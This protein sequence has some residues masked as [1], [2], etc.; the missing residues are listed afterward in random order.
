MCSTRL[1]T[2]CALCLIGT[3]Q[4]NR[5]CRDATANCINT[6]DW[7][8]SAK[9]QTKTPYRERS[10]ECAFEVHQFSNYFVFVLHRSWTMKNAVK[11]DRECTRPAYEIRAI[12]FV[13][14]M[15]QCVQ[16]AR[17]LPCD[18][19]AGEWRII[20]V[21]RTGMRS[22]IIFSLS[23][24]RWW[25]QS[26][27]KRVIFYH[28][29]TIRYLLR[30]QFILRE[31]AILTHYR[32]PWRNKLEDV[33]R[34]ITLRMPEDKID[35]AESNRKRRRICRMAIFC[36]P[37]GKNQNVEMFMQCK[38]IDTMSLHN[39]RFWKWQTN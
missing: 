33:F 9:T 21:Q 7:L 24:S 30:F 12:F 27:G 17:C 35:V 22:I 32:V 26:N 23:S 5:L 13:V 25:N 31:Q 39:G 11:R 15:P 1:A 8:F 18:R 37:V 16:R 34:C 10:C 20:F 14:R 2:Y 36:Q 3:F 29:T 19:R 4:W 28:D 38:R 6:I